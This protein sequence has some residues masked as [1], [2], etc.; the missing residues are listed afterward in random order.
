M[1]ARTAADSGWDHGG[2]S[3]PLPSPT[4]SGLFSHW[5][6]QPLAVA[7]AIAAAAWYAWAMRAVA[8]RGQP[9]PGLRAVWFGLG[10]AGFVWA[11]NGFAQAYASSLYWIWTSQTLALLLVVPLI[12]LAGQPLQLARSAGL[13]F[14]DAF[15]QSRPG[16]VLANPLVGP[17]L[18]PTLSVLLFF[19]PLPG[20]AIRSAAFGWVL[21]I[22]LVLVGMLIVLPLT[23]VAEFPDS[24][25]VGMTLA[26]G[27]VELVLDAIPGIVLRLRTTLVTS[28]FDYRTVWPWS[29]HPIHDQQTAGAVLWCV[30]EL[31]DLPFLLLMY[32]R[33]LRADARDAA[34]VDAVLD[35]ERAARGE[36]VDDDTPA[37]DEPWW[38][39]DPEM[40]RRMRHQG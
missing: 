24:L 37:A 3:Q 12:M 1:A 23:A 22:V 21:Q 32:R 31:I 18:V 38:L 5:S 20:W 8:R 16:R 17:A 15:L 10:V 7:A 28:Y 27:M 26:I 34:E 9:W 6:L 30:S 14:V 39:S 19:G 29:P 35:A 2:V 13:G 11:T 40:Q 25:A 33:W 4:L 36:R